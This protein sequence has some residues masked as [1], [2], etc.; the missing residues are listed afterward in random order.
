MKIIIFGA[1]GGV[2]FEC[3]RQ[4]IED[5]N[6]EH[7]TAIT[8]RPLDK[9]MISNKLTNIIHENFLDYNPL[10]NLFE[11]HQACIWALGV[12]Q[13]AVN[14]SEYIKITYDYTL[15]AAKTMS[16][17]NPNMRFIFVS[18]R[19]ADSTEQSRFLFG[20][21]KGKTENALIKESGLKEIYTVRPAA[22]LF[23]QD[24]SNKPWYVRA[25]LPALHIC[26]VVKPSWVITSTEL[27]HAIL[28]L[29][30]NGHHA[31][32]FENQDLK[33]IINENH[34]VA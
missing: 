28:Y 27:A 29:V 7:I 8:R 30:K 14:E 26:K 34:R 6:I 16:Q 9:N 15:A 33:N 22:I 25:F 10:L 24:T 4:A 21:I 18:G 19:G 12:S 17:V 5:Q 32:L 3:V 13:N 1:N 11:N 20:R 31:T 2:G 23:T